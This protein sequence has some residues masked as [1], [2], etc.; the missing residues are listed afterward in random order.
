MTDAEREEERYAEARHQMVERQLRRRG[1]V[2]ESVLRAMAEVPRHRFVDEA[3][4]ERAYD[5]YPLPIGAGQTIS[6]PY[7]VA[8]M[9]ELCCPKPGDRAL[10]VGAGS[11]YQTA[12]L[13]RLCG[14]V[15]STEIVEEL[16]ETAQRTLTELGCSNIALEL[17]DGSA[18]WPEQA[19]FDIIL[20]AAGAPTIPEELREQLAEGGRLVIPVG[21]REVQTL[22]RVL[23][24]GSELVTLEDT[25]CRFVDLRGKHGWDGDQSS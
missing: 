4:R 19:P 1:I 9:T 24:H 5:D 21:G 25:S 22:L 18:G 7:M 17:R 14:Q 3:Y 6:Q 8:R 13:A 23:R 12:V 20:V 15:F 11:G 2:D 10:E 16:A